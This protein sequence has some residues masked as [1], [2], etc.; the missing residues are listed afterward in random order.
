MRIGPFLVGA[1]F[2]VT[3]ATP[4]A[5]QGTASPSAFVGGLGGLTFG[6]AAT[7]G[8]VAGQVGFRISR[9]LFVI[10][11]FGRIADVVPSEVADMIDEFEDQAELEGV[12]V[13]LEVKVPAIYGFGGVRW[14]PSRGKINPFV[15]GGVGFAH[16][17][18]KIKAIVDGVDITEFVEDEIGDI[19]GL[20]TNEFLI[21]VGGGANIGLT[22]AVSVDAGYRFT[23]IFT[24]DPAVNSSMIYAAVKILLGR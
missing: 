2:V 21:A 16:L 8:A 10:G 5:A 6:S 20:S 14:A 17:K 19:E 15:E 1:M 11:E 7:S 12:S 18:G 24:D 13:D 9:D 23:R 4:V 22:S 3:L